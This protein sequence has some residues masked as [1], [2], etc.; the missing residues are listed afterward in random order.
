MNTELT[1]ACSEVK[2]QHTTH[3]LAIVTRRKKIELRKDISITFHWVKGHASL[4]GNERADC[5]AKTV[6]SYKPT[7]T[8]Y[9]I[10]VSRGKRLLK[11]YYIK[12]WNAAYT[13]SEK[14]SH[15]KILIPSVLH[16]MTL[17]KP[18]PYTIPNKPWLLSLILLLKEKGAYTTMQLP[19][20]GRTNGPASHDILHP[21][22][23]RKPSGAA[24]TPAPTNNAILHKHGRSLQ[25]NQKH[26]PHATGTI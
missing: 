17:T 2:V 10:P 23:Q 1:R 19:R 9:A 6:A 18:H 12:I 8:Y 25:T 11:E 16:R 21:I 3:P 14:A 22:L 15:T 7:T 26:I 24:K 20:K 13:N 4:K 5:L